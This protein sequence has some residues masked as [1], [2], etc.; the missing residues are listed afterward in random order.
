[1]E[2]KTYP[3]PVDPE[4][5]MRCVRW[6]DED[7]LDAITPR[8]LSPHPNT[9]TYSKRLAEKLVEDYGKCMPVAI[10]RPS[11]VTPIW[12]EPV[13]G[14]VDN[15]NGPVGLLVGAGKGV[16]RSMYCKGEYHAEVVPVDMAI[17][18]MIASAWKT[19]NNKEKIVQVYNLSQSEVKPVTWK[20]V[21]DMGR[22]HINEYPFEG[23]VWYPDGNM[24]S[25]RLAHNI[26]V[27]FLHFLPA[28]LIDFLMLIFRQKR[29]M[30]RIQ[31]KIQDGLEVLQYFT[32]RE[33]KFINKNFLSLHNS[34]SLADQRRFYMDYSYIDNEE[35]LKTI[36]LGARQFCM[37]EDLSSLPRARK[38]MRRYS[39]DFY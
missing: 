34:L 7:M 12:K 29:F 32:T 25:T 28:Y 30:V 19:A 13:A 18:A 16:I 22:M 11:I 39:N 31:R 3:V 33:W 4:D 21:L 10:V 35:Y 24:R 17:N 2:E 38:H 9:Y 27:I 5:I 8:L 14:W 36:I 6:M 1:M 23:V 37:K 20:E 26:C 15:L